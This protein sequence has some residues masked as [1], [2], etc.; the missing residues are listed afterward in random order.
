M[1]LN[2]HVFFY[3]LSNFLNFP[4]IYNEI[5]HEFGFV[6]VYRHIYR[7]WVLLVGS[8]CRKHCYSYRIDKYFIPESVSWYIFLQWSKKVDYGSIIGRKIGRIID[9]E[10]WGD[11]TH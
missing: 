9:H 7:K 3:I 11:S 1:C 6:Y 4:L 5:C 2:I 8:K 10:N